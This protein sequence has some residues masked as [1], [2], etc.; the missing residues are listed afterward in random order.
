MVLTFNSAQHATAELQQLQ[1]LQ[2]QQLELSNRRE[3]LPEHR[4]PYLHVIYRNCCSQRRQPL[5]LSAV[6]EAKRFDH[7][8]ISSGRAVAQLGSTD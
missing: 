5:Q 1:Q 8:F 4:S 7:L 3:Y 6:P 2:R